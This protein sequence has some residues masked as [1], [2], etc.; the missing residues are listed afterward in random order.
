MGMVRRDFGLAG[1]YQL[2]DSLSAAQLMTAMVTMTLFV[3]CIASATVLWKERGWQEGGVVLTLSWVLAF[4]I[5]GVAAWVLN[6]WP[7]LL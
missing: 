4:A 7:W 2:Q 5:G 1:F 6:L 3:P